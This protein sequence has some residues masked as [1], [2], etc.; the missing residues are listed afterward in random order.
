VLVEVLADLPLSEPASVVLVAVGLAVTAVVGV[1]FEVAPVCPE[2]GSGAGRTRM[3]RTKVPTKSASTT[4][5]EGR[6]LGR[7]C[8]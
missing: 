8:P 7:F 1:G 5:V 2:A 4:Q 6:I 3:Y